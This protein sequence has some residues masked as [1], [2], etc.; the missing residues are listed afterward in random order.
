MFI[1]TLPRFKNYIYQ[2]SIL[3][4]IYTC[5]FIHYC[6]PFFSLEELIYNYIITLLKNIIPK[7]GYEYIKNKIL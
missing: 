2:D 5:F 7:K 4:D 6:A 3:S 1:L